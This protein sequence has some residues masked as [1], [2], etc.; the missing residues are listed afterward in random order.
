MRISLPVKCAAYIC[1]AVLL[2]VLA[3]VFARGMALPTDYNPQRIEN[4]NADD[5]DYDAEAVDTVDVIAPIGNAHRRATLYLFVV[6]CTLLGAAVYGWRSYIRRHREHAP[7]ALLW[8]I[9]GG[10]VLAFSLYALLSFGADGL[11]A[12]LNLMQMILRLLPIPF[13]VRALTV[14]L[15]RDMP[16]KARLPFRLISIVMLLGMVVL[17]PPTIFNTLLR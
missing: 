13:G 12:K 8:L 5:V 16:P 10:L 15:S 1:F 2:L 3:V 7:D 9:A 11:A 4:T 14:A 6:G 17:V